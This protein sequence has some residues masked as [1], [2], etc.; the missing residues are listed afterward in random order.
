VKES[1]RERKA[2]LIERWFLMM[3]FSRSR[4]PCGNV[5]PFI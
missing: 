4:I 2:A 5:V 3:E 1:A